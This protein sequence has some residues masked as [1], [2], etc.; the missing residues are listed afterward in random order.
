MITL[1]PDVPENVAAFKATGEISKEDFEN[2]VIPHVKAKVNTFDELNYLFYLDTDLDQ[3]SA[4]A[5]FQDA[6]LGLTNIM[7]W[8]RAAIVTD[9]KGV[10]NF[11]DIFSVV[12]PGEFKSFPE[13]DLENALF[14][15]ANGN[16]IND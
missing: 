13:E 10:Q 16:E 4:G 1:I 14:W 9:K 11:T 12:M 3:I 15:C 8:N 7:K 5:W 2:L 6:L